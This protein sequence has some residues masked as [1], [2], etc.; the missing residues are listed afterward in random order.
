MLLCTM[1]LNH[2]YAYFLSEH[3]NVLNYQIMINICGEVH[4]RLFF[5]KTNYEIRFN[6]EQRTTDWLI[7][8]LSFPFNYIQLEG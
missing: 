5:F 6:V 2:T 7:R 3:L 1:H 8:S 4:F